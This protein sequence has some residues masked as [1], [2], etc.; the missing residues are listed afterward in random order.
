MTPLHAAV[1]GQRCFLLNCFLLL[2]SGAG[3]HGMIVQPRED[4]GGAQRAPGSWRGLGQH[5][6]HRFAGQPPS[7]SMLCAVSM[8]IGVQV[9]QLSVLGTA[10]LAG[11]PSLPDG[12]MS[13]LCPDPSGSLGL[14][15]LWLGLSLGK[16]IMPDSSALC[17]ACRLGDPQLDPPIDT[18]Q[19]S[20]GQWK[21]F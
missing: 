18:Q 9:M 14:L 20:V 8:L 1:H 21:C 13:L 5:S 17:L 15:H 11:D 19:G 2:F 6:L 12:R 10:L 16:G 7:N 4:P 3:D